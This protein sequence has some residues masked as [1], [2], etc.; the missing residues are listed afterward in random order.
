M[1]E[2]KKNNP[3]IKE[4]EKKTFLFILGALIAGVSLFFFKQQPI[5]SFVGLMIGAFLMIKA[6]S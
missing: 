5:I 6:L 4:S 3:I 1:A 2:K